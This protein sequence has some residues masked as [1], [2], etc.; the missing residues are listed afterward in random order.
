MSLKTAIATVRQ[1]AKQFGTKSAFL[2]VGYRAAGKLIP[3]MAFK[4]MTAV[5]ADVD[6][7][8]LSPGPYEARLATKKDLL[9]VMKD[10]EW[11]SQLDEAFVEKAMNAGDEC[12]GIFDQGKMV[13]MGWYSMN[14]TPVSENAEIVF[15]PAWVYMYKGYTQKTHR[16]K[17]LHGIGMSSALKMYTEQGA[18]GLISY[19]EVNNFASLRSIEKMGYRIFGEVGAA[20]I[21]GK[22]RTACTNGCKPFGFYLSAT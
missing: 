1:N 15:D 9:K 16:G 18:R 3:L 5:L 12:F 21:G 22:L 6:P 2:D 14:A 7:T 11:Q 10:P 17:R 4:G 19:V 8:L 20:E 13:S